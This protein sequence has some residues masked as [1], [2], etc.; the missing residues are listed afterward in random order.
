M[1]DI[2]ILHLSHRPSY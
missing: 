2:R 1:N